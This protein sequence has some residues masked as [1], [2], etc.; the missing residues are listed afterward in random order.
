MKILLIDFTKDEKSWQPILELEDMHVERATVEE[1]AEKIDRSDYDLLVINFH[2]IEEEAPWLERFLKVRFRL[3]QVPPVLA[4]VR[5]KQKGDVE[6]A[7]VAGCDLVI[8]KPF[9]SLEFKTK[10]MLFER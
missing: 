5:D 8:P 10:A 4:L 3:G 2:T 7:I 9:T 1:L 6:R